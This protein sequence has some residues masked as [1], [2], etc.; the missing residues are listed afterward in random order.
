MLLPHARPRA[1]HRDID[2]LT[3]KLSR[4]LSSLQ[5]LLSLLDP[6]LH[7]VLGLVNRS[8]K[9]LL[10]LWRG[11]TSNL[12]SESRDRTRFPQVFDLQLTQVRS[13]TG[14]VDG[15]QRFTQES[16]NGVHGKV[17]R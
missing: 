5:R 3:L 16:F 2:A 9:S 4:S 11:Q 10:L 1:G 8:A 12:A 13:R 17:H 7:R 14:T 6:R 15:V